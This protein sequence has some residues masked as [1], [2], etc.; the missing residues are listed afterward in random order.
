MRVC[1][2]I[3]EIKNKLYGNMF[4]FIRKIVENREARADA[5]AAAETEAIKK[6]AAEAAG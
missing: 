3:V 4:D 1:W 2:E 6:A 5:K